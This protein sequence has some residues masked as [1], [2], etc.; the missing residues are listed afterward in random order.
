MTKTETVIGDI[1]DAWRVQDL[2]WLASYL[3]DDFCHMIHIPT[4]IH[5]WAVLATARLP[6]S[7]AWA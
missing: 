2:D 5:P 4:E 7:S 6:P 3:P 1:Y